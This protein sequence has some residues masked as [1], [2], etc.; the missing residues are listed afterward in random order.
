MRGLERAMKRFVIHGAAAVKL[1]RRML[2]ESAFLL[3][4]GAASSSTTFAQLTMTGAY[5]NRLAIACYR[6]RI[7]SFPGG[8][9]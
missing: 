2:V 6:D 1:T 8:V 3:A 5:A 7:G 9:F 4:A